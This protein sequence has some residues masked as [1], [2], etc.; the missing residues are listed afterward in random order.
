MNDDTFHARVVLSM[1]A[2][3]L[4]TSCTNASSEDASATPDLAFS[5]DE[6]WPNPRSPAGIGEGRVLLTNN[7]EDTVSLFDL[8]SIASGDLLETARIPVG[9]IPVELE[10]PHHAAIDPS[11]EFYYVGISNY[12]PGT[13]SGPHGAHGTGTGDGYCLKY[14]ASDN[15]LEAFVRVDPSPGDL[16]TSPD[17][18]EIYV[19]HYDLRRI[20][21][22]FE[23][24]GPAGDMDARLI[25]IDAETM[26]RKAAVALCPA[27]HGVRTSP[28]GARLYASCLSDE[29]AVVDVRDPSYPVRRVRL[30]GAGSAIAPRHEPYAVTVSPST[31]EVW[32]SCLFSKELHV[33]DPS[34][35][36][37]QED[38]TL[39]LSGAPLFGTFTRDGSTLFLAQQIEE[40]VL[41]IHA[42]T[43]EIRA[44]VRLEPSDCKNAHQVIL[45]PD[46]NRALLVCEGNHRSP[47]TLVLI[48]LANGGRVVRSAPAG[49]FPDF[50]GLLR[51]EEP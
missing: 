22:A 13:G 44:S 28:D 26:T 41:E 7:L 48:D 3:L 30:P 6:H 14:R 51:K 50:V 38:R 10:G 9:L 25:V 16:V 42:A 35:L 4:A 37:M 27:P 19:T 49:V 33:L 31:G 34:S 29:I 21:D 43:G 23:R 5:L 36:T 2:G 18:R 47:G 45:T 17:G 12:V 39:S 20:Q 40:R 32:V 15:T 11:G 1:L 24:G 8:A 46:E